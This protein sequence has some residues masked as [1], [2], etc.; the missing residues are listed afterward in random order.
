MTKIGT[1]AEKLAADY[2]Q[3]NGLRLITSNFR[4]RFG[5]IDLILRDGNMLVFTEVRLRTNQAFGD[6]AASIT[7]A[8]QA[9]VVRTAAYYLQRHGLDLPCRFDVVLLH[10]L[11][12]AGIEWI[13]GAF[14]GALKCV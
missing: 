10:R 12:G 7:H 4:C 5:E 11:D 1:I 13:R 14:E 8:K 9:K 2:L 6:A 3:R